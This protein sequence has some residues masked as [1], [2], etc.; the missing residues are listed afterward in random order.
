MKSKSIESAPGIKISADDF[1]WPDDFDNTG[2]P[3][4]PTKIDVKLDK[5]K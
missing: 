4:S 2:R 1:D 3:L 5:G